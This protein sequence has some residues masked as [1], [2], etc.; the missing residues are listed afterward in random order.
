MTSADVGSSLRV[1]VTAGNWIS[2]VGLA[3]SERTAV[4]AKP[5]GVAPGTK[6][7]GS[8]TGPTGS[9]GGPRKARRR[10]A[11]TRVRMHPRRFAVAHRRP[12]AGTRLDGAAITWRLD[13]QGDRT[14]DVPAGARQGR[15]AAAGSRSARSSARAASGAG[16]V[17]FRGRFG[18][19]LLAPGRYRVV[20]RAKHG[21]QRSGPARMRFKVVRR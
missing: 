16:V 7:G 12:R 13:P 17:R 5:G 4:V 1:V 15:A 21:G 20:V 3:V 8:G 11:L 6:P 10:L 14:A 19:R 2:A 9:G 18:A